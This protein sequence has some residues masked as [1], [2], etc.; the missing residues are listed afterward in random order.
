MYMRTL[1]RVGAGLFALTLFA[2]LA[3]C[4]DDDD[5]AGDD[6]TDTTEAGGEGEQAAG[7]RDEFCTALVDFNGAVPEVELDDTSSEADIKAVGEDLG[8]LSQT[9]ADEAP[10]DLAALAGELNDI[11]QPLNEGD[12]SQ[13][14]SDATFETY[15]QFVDGA[16]DA[17][18]FETVAVTGVEYAFEGVPETVPAG[19]VAFAFS[20]EGEEEHE[21]ILVKKAD[22]ATQSF[23]EIANLP[24]EES[25]SLVEFK[26]AT[27]APPGGESSA[28]AELDAGEYAMFCFIPVGGAE[29]GP[30][31]FTEGMLQEFTVE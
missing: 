7:A 21:M 20:N 24:E 13:F 17:C 4:G 23:E 10:D 8:P 2:G 5:D 15:G 1:Q 14:N 19:T 31:H 29:D 22:G 27:F 6:A 26:S 30:P 9:L 3:A 18:D 25:E 16:I 12:A 28:L 11:V